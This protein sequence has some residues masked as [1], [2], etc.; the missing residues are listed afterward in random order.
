MGTWVG[1]GEEMHMRGEVEG[2]GGGEGGEQ[3][4]VVA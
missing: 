4:V 1:M 2:R 3:R